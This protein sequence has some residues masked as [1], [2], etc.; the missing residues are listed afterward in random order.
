LAQAFQKRGLPRSA[1]SDNGAAMTAAEITQGL[2]RLGIL[3]QTT[4][5]YS[6]YQNAKQEAFWGPVEGRLVVFIPTPFSLSLV[7][8]VLRPECDDVRMPANSYISLNTIERLTFE[9]NPALRC[10]ASNGASSRH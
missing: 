3:H 7:A 4:L 5:P 8:N 9:K 2:T 10:D 1:L 6:P